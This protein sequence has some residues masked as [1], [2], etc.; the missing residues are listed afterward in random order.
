MHQGQLAPRDDAGRRF[1]HRP[2]SEQSGSA[3]PRP[4]RPQGECACC[5]WCVLGLKSSAKE[6]ES[7][8]SDGAGS[9]A[10]CWRGRLRFVLVA[11]LLLA[12]AHPSHEVPIRHR[13]NWLFPRLF[14][15]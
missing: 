10:D 3:A 9:V 7:F 4:W 2:R 12:K 11:F 14:D 15:K 8:I 1:Q 5:C 13:Q 6:R